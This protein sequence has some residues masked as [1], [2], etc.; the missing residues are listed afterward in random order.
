MGMA[1]ILDTSRLRTFLAQRLSISPSAVEAMVLGS[2]GDL[3]VPVKSAITVNGT[4]VT[5]LLPEPELD[6]ILQRT[7]DGGAEVVKLLKTGSAFYAPASSAVQMAGAILQDRHTV[8]PACVALDGEY[9]LRDVCI[10]VP[11]R[12]GAAGVEEI[13]ELSLT[14]GERSALTASADKV[15]IDIKGLAALQAKAGRAP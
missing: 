11:V 5:G 10:G 9:G 12:L 4:P 8:L 7:K 6:Q 2:H 15:R 14:A 13:V 1:G 3:M